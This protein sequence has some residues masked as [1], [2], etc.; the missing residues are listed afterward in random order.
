MEVDHQP[1]GEYPGSGHGRRAPT[2]GDA[3]TRPP[4]PDQSTMSSLE[5]SPDDEHVDDKRFEPL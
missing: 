4:D 2:R 5:D 3:P 1:T